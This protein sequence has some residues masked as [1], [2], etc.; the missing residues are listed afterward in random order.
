M[1][2]SKGFT[3]IEMLIVIAI[4]AIL[5]G[6]VLT[7]VRGFQQQARDTRRIGDLRNIQALVELYFSRNS[8]YPADLAAI[9]NLGTVPKDPGTQNAYTYDR[10]SDRLNYC[11][12]ATL[13]NDNNATDN[14][15]NCAFLSSSGCA[16]QDTL[17]YCVGSN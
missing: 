1:N 10:S 17:T 14:D 7:G 15:S 2:K 11:L 8:E 4:I 16:T 6:V 9:A 12:R 3:L 13:E 5:A